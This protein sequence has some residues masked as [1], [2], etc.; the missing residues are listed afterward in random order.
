ME[1]YQQLL[2]SEP[3]TRRWNN[4]CTAIFD[5]YYR[6][7]ASI[8]GKT[9]SRQLAEEIASTTLYKVMMGIEKFRPQ[10]NLE[11]DGFTAWIV[12]I[13]LNCMIDE[14]R[15]MRESEEYLE[16]IVLNGN[17]FSS[18]TGRDEMKALIFDLSMLVSKDDLKFLLTYSD[19]GLDRTA[20]KLKMSMGA[21]RTKA[22]RLRNRLK[23]FIDDF[24]MD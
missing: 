9:V 2:E 20:E 22:Y 15:S 6:H 3:N 4:V 11:H 16:D 1:L 5:K 21:V 7:V 12:K 13:A 19:L 23:P 10:E 8:V 24:L 14:L 17:V 18:Y